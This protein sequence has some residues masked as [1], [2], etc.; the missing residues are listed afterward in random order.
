MTDVERPARRRSSLL[1]LILAALIPVAAILGALYVIWIVRPRQANQALN[2]QLVL[3]TV[4]LATP[5]VNKLDA[6]F[7]DANNDLIAD[8]PADASKLI[9][10]DPLVFS[11]VAVEDPGP[12]KE[13]FQAFS[14][15]L[16][17][18]TGKR[19]EYLMAT[20]SDE[21]LRALR[22]GNLH[23]T[24]LNTGSVPLAVDACGF[25]PTHKLA[26]EGTTAGTYEMEII[27]PAGSAITSPRQLSGKEI[28]L[29]EGN[30]NSGFKAPLVL[31]QKDFGLLPAKHFG[32]R[33]S[34]DH[35]AS[36]RGIANKE[37]E[38]A[39]VANDLLRRAIATGDI[40][41][42]SVRSI[43]KSPSFPTAAFG[44]AHNLTPELAKKVREAFDTFQWKGTGLEKEFGPSQ[45]TRFAPADY[46]K[47]WALIRE[48][49]EKIGSAHVLK[50]PGTQPAT[51]PTTAPATEP[52]AASP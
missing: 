28:A 22:D 21:Q 19:V 32:I 40:Q 4:G 15:H 50:E 8:P 11:F 46:Q 42:N 29:T 34:G 16:A 49:D 41:E 18:V 1:T 30:S 24:G 45:Q 26:G 3:Q 9:D 52:V 39:A 38:A 13:V 2:E 43:Y 17:K 33:Y 23:V 31:L 7:S 6:R 37:Y 25:V 12:Y 44:H 51:Q 47:E 10:P 48:I 35:M 14:D 20:S 27:V 36:I 5:V